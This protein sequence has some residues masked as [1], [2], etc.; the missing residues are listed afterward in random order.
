LIPSQWKC[1]THDY[2]EYSCT[3]ACIKKFY[4]P[5]KTPKIGNNGGDVAMDF[6]D[7]KVEQARSFLE[8]IDT[9]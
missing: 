7:V 4:T 5:L 2:G 3:Y 6:C 8:L 1:S 9:F